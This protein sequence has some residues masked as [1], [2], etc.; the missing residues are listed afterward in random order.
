MHISLGRQ[1]T[2]AIGDA[3]KRLSDENILIINGENI[4]VGGVK[5]EKTFSKD[6][7]LIWYLGKLDYQVLGVACKWPFERVIPWFMAELGDECIMRNH[8]MKPYIIRAIEDGL[9]FAFSNGDQVAVSYRAGE[10]TL[11]V[12]SETTDIHHLCD[13]VDLFFGLICSEYELYHR[14]KTFNLLNDKTC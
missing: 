3:F 14:I 2:N 11:Y 6:D 5:I 13:L 7:Y 8:A 9:S 4:E 1:F 12:D 10:F